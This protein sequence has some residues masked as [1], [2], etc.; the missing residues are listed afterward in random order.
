[1]LDVC[2]AHYLLASSAQLLLFEACNSEC[3]RTFRAHP[4]YIGI[5][6][7]LMEYRSGGQAFR[8]RL[9]EW[10]AL[11]RTCFV[12]ASPGSPNASPPTLY[13]SVFS[14]APKTATSPA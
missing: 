4:L 14:L 11:W 7:D 6:C 2:V 10:G 5:V 3:L 8:P 13:L 9:L 1:M 12:L